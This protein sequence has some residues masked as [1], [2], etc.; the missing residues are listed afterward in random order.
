MR[1]IILSLIAMVVL[2]GCSTS[3]SNT[4][5]AIKCTEL[6]NLRRMYGDKYNINIFADEDAILKRERVYFDYK[7]GSCIYKMSWTEIN[8][9]S[10]IANNEDYN[11]IEYYD[12]EKDIYLIGHSGFGR[13]PDEFLIKTSEMFDAF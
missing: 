7:Y 6:Y 12:L 1:K 5:L 3:T 8:Y 13:L 11:V 9:D 10:S 2:A 4:E